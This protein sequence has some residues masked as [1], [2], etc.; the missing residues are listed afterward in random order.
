MANTL[1]LSTS[2][3]LKLLS[4]FR[5]TFIR[6]SPANVKICRFCHSLLVGYLEGVTENSFYYVKLHTGHSSQGR[7]LTMD[8]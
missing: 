7:H 1:K 6:D 4:V 3:P 8:I 5:N 2:L